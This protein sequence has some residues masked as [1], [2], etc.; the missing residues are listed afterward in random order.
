MLNL[1]KMALLFFPNE[2]ENNPFCN[3]HSV[4]ADSLHVGNHFERACN[5]PEVT[6]RLHQNL[7]LD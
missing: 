3:V 6:R 5:H 7:F 4:I 1:S 2:R